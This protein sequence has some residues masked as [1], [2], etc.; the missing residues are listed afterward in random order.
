MF[1]SLHIHILPIISIIPIFLGGVLPPKGIS[2][3]FSLAFRLFTSPYPV[4]ISFHSN[5]TKNQ[6]NKN[7]FEEILSL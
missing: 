3:V 4:F 1:F 5:L 6:E 7:I 2:I